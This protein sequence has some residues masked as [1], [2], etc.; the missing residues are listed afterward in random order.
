MRLP[1]CAFFLVLSLFISAMNGAHAAIAPLRVALHALTIKDSWTTGIPG[2][3]AAVVPAV[4]FTDEG[5]AGEQGSEPCHNAPVSKSIGTRY[6]CSESSQSEIAG[7]R[8]CSY[9]V[10]IHFGI[11]SRPN[12]I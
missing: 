7:I 5:P 10:R 6:A 3:I 4:P 9:S 1:F 2:K 11:R 8:A 12:A